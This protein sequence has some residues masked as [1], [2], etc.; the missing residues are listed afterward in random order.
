MIIGKR[1]FDGLED[2]DELDCGKVAQGNGG[3]VSRSFVEHRKLQT[4]PQ[5]REPSLLE[6]LFYK[7]MRRDNS[8]I[9]Q[10]FRF[11]VENNFLQDLGTV[12][13]VFPE[14]A[15]EKEEKA[16]LRNQLAKP[17]SSESTS[18]SGSEQSDIGSEEG[19][20]LDG[21]LRPKGGNVL[22]SKSHLND[23]TAAIVDIEMGNAADS[24]TKAAKN[25]ND[26]DGI[27]GNGE[28]NEGSCL[29]AE[30]AERQRTYDKKNDEGNGDVECG[31]ICD[32][33]QISASEKLEKR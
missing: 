14:D 3:H 28:V 25:S 15:A 11:L 6:K 2:Q 5:G 16:D 22:N 23:G 18:E 4:C 20:L 30:N 31:E 27:E 13:L 21:C 29:K 8:Y 12:P 26:I 33:N 1:R 19:E 24:D 7:E 10:C 32:R 17:S 9:L